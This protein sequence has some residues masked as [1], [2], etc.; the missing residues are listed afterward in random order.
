MGSRRTATHALVLLVGRNV[1]Q[2]LHALVLDVL[3]L[4]MQRLDLQFALPCSDNR[5]ALGNITRLFRGRRDAL[6]AAVPRPHLP[7]RGC[8][9]LAYISCRFASTVRIHDFAGQKLFKRDPTF[10]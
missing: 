8:K 10:A 6:D 1:F 9:L 7:L 5:C 2:Q 3:V 4:E